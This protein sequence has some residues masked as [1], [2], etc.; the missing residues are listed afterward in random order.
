MP[1]I[2]PKNGDT[3]VEMSKPTAKEG[4][5]SLQYPMLTKSNYLTWAMKMKV[6]MRVQGVWDVVEP[7]DSKEA[8]DEC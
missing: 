1:K 6:Y 8:I 4:T 3:D 7:T 2:M 5:L